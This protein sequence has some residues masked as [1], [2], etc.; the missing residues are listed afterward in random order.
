MKQSL[1]ISVQ[2]HINYK[3]LS[4]KQLS[5]LSTLQNKHYKTAKKHSLFSHK[6]AIVASALVL[7]V[8]LNVYFSKLTNIPGLSIEQRIAEEVSSNHIKLKPLEIRSNV[9]KDISSYFTHLDFL[10]VSPVSLPLSEQSLL[11]GRYC[12]IQGVTALQLRM[13]D[14]KTNKIQTLY[15]TEFDKKVFKNFS[16]LTGD[17]KAITVYAKGMKVELWIENDI[18]FALI[19]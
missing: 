3:N 12:S 9:L 4:R 15:E 6:M 14:K 11:G 17:G 16:N 18:L 5:Q 8:T 10:P 1:K 7:S 19:E 2:K 13:L